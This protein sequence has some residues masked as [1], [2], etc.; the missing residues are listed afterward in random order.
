[1]CAVLLLDSDLQRI[2]GGSLI[3]RGIVLTAAHIVAKFRENPKALVVRCGDYDSQGDSEPRGHQDRGV[4][5]LEIHWGFEE[6]TTIQYNNLAVL[7]MEQ[8]FELAEH[9]GPVCLPHPDDVFDNQTN[10]FATGW[11][12]VKTNRKKRIPGI[13]KEIPLHVVEDA[14]CEKT[15]QTWPEFNRYELHD[16]LLCAAT[17]GDTCIV[18]GG[19]LVS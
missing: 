9:I 13:L 12:K 15:Y 7:F 19:G 11:G 17:Y 10:C 14:E 2:G 1:M 3:A 4:R 6:G 8:E 5:A 18:D 16:S